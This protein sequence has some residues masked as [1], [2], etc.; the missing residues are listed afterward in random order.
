[1]MTCVCSN[2]EKIIIMTAKTNEFFIVVY[3]VQSTKWMQNYFTLKVLQ[4]SSEWKRADE[5]CVFV[6][7]VRA[8][9]NSV[10]IRFYGRTGS[11]L[12]CSA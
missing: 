10:N 7:F 1:M 3:K 8:T 2:D 12:I 5:R 4:S 6:C 11:T 9:M